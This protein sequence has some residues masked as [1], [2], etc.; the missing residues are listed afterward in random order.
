MALEQITLDNLN[1]AE[2][3]TAIRRRNT[4]GFVR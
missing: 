1:W 2:M 4:C 3:V